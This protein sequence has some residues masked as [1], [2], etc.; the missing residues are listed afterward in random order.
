MKG[1]GDA[2]HK[3][4]EKRKGEAFLPLPRVFLLQSARPIASETGMDRISP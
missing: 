3:A 4:V 2:V 1:K